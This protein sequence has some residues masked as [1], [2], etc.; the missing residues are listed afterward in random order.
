MLTKKYSPHS[1]QHVH[2]RHL[3]KLC[4]P[5]LTRQCRKNRPILFCRELIKLHHFRLQLEIF[6]ILFSLSLSLT[7]CIDLSALYLPSFC[8]S[9]VV[10][11][12]WITL[13]NIFDQLDFGNLYWFRPNWCSASHGIVI[14]NLL[15]HRF[16][17]KNNC[18]KI[19]FF[20]PWIFTPILL[21]LAFSWSGLLKFFLIFIISYFCGW[22]SG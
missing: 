15:T 1:Y 13:F 20:G 18:I 10:V 7:D 4:S 2:L 9:V 22:F 12:L 16:G 19:G 14:F 8:D 3:Y 5:K 21:R 17:N 11:V 6:N